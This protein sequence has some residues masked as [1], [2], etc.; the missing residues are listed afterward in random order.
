MREAEFEQL[1]A[2][3][4]RGDETSFAALYR[5]LNPRLLAYFRAHA[6]DVADDLASETWVA[7]ARNLCQFAGDENGFRAWTFTIAHRRLVEHWRTASRR[8]GRSES[9]VFLDDLASGDDTE[10][11]GLVEVTTAEAAALI[12]TVLTPEQAD[13]ILL[14]CLVDL[15]VSQV[16]EITGKS[17]GAVRL[18]QHRAL[19][20]LADAYSQ[21]L[22]W[23]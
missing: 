2:G 22:A 23:R 12:R 4:K 19:R 10:W 17:P 13:V 16:A 7:V 15:D 6:L 3:A 8:P 9:E 21:E 1:L 18:L 5:E 14:R 20:R 11:D